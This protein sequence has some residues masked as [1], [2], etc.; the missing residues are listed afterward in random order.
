MC[1]DLCTG[2]GRNIS[3]VLARLGAPVKLVSAVGSDAFGGSLRASF[4][5]LGIVRAHEQ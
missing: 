4:K 3:E 1:V 5:T 2:V